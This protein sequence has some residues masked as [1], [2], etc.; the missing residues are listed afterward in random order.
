MA[1]AQL[2][3]TL[4]DNDTF[5]LDPSATEPT[6][7]ARFDEL[8]L[9]ESMLATLDS[10]GYETPSP[11]QA[12]VIPVALSGRDVLG[13]ARTGTGKTASFAIPI[14]ETME[15]RGKGAPP[16]AI[17]LVPTRELAVQVTGEFQR[18][19]GER[20][21]RCVAVYGGKP[22]KAQ[23]SKLERGAD[24]V[25]GTPGRVLDH[26]GRRTIDLKSLR[27]VVLDEADRMLDIGFRPD[28][29]KILRQCPDRR[30]TL[31]LSATVAPPVKRLAERYMHEP[32]ML[33]FSP[34]SKSVDMIEQHFFTVDGDRKFDLLNR[35]L[36]R[37][38]P[39]QTI[40]FCRTKRGCDKIHERLSK[41]RKGVGCIHGDLP[42]GARDS[43]M[44]AFRAEE[45]TLLVATDVVGRG[46][47]VTSISHIINYDIPQSSDDYVHRVGRTGRMGREG[48]A[49]TFVTRE[50]G[51]EL[52][53][54][55]MLINKV[56]IEDKIE[57]FE[58]ARPAEKRAAAAVK[59]FGAGVQS[60]ANE[61]AEA[62]ETPAETAAPKPA[63]FGRRGRTKHRRG[64]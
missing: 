23:I 38:N 59:F 18:L 52:T 4:T 36:E 51:E 13:Q 1:T 12:G 7:T 9:S 15:D 8:G 32:T 43:V 40:V 24:V 60:E 26:I 17:V 46:I 29:E 30:Q 39:S 58:A 57:G 63:P 37:E 49:Y 10:I 42:Q 22:I 31:L 27:V 62:A 28:I 44:K 34:K 19:C 6:V 55:E 45:I 33:D 53:R 16:Q 14:L 61:E 35:L 20:K 5:E 64:L 2:E 50:E 54:I 56:L 25:I 48:V 41:K 3:D 47:D 11:V 21:V